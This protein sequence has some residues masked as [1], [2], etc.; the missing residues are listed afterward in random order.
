MRESVIA[1]GSFVFLL[2][3]LYKYLPIINSLNIPVN[4]PAQINAHISL[5]FRHSINTSNII[6]AV[7]HLNVLL[8]Q[9]R[10]LMYTI[11]GLFCMPSP[12]LL[13][14]YASF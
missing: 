5:M 12:L 2:I 9:Q 10:L 3:L 1:T 6:N 14:V 13:T 8:L 4:I 7:Q 11:D